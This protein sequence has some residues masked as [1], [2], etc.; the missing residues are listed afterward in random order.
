[1]L[2]DHLR[3]QAGKIQTMAAML[4]SKGIHGLS[5]VRSYLI[6]CHLQLHKA[7]FHHHGTQG[8]FTNSAHIPGTTHLKHRSFQVDSGSRTKWRLN[9][10]IPLTLRYHT[11]HHTV[12][13]NSK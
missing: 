5:H 2:V 6:C 12:A 13:S 8:S 4:L 3:I 1:M 10:T 11:L 7:N 9:R